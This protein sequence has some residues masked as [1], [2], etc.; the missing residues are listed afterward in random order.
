MCLFIITSGAI[1][2]DHVV[3]WFDVQ[4][5]GHDHGGEDFHRRGLDGRGLLEIPTWFFQHCVN[6]GAKYAMDDF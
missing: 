6:H 1:C 3:F 2:S 4:F 5:H